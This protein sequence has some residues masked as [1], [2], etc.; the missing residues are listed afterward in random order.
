MDEISKR[1]AHPCFFMDGM[2]QT[3]RF[4]EFIN[5]FV[6]T[7]NEEKDEAKLWEFWLHRVYGKSYNDF[8]EEL[9]TDSQNQTM[10]KETIETTVQNSLDILKTF[11]PTQQGG[12]E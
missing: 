6:K 7:T 2:I 1:Y 5:K 12:E 3:G 8:K 9:K 10:S 11:K 4:C